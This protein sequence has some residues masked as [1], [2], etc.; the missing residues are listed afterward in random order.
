M[1]KFRICCTVQCCDD[2][3]F[4]KCPMNG[5]DVYLVDSNMYSGHC[6]DGVMISVYRHN[7]GK[8]VDFNR[9]STMLFK[10]MWERQ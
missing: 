7:F 9:M 2:D 8:S 5:A 1:K 4:E 10:A 6:F 3:L